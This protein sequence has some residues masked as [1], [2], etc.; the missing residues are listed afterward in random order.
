M[1][2][3][4]GLICNTRREGKGE[5]TGTL[6]S[7]LLLLHSIFFKGRKSMEL[8]LMSGLNL[9]DPNFVGITWSLRNRSQPN[10]CLLLYIRP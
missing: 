1:N 2:G 3:S 9:D 5:K 10:I 4:M 8:E 6:T 7:L